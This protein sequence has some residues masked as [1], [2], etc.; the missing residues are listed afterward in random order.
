MCAGVCVSAHAH[1][2]LPQMCAAPGAVARDESLGT[3]AGAAPAP[4]WRRSVARYATPELLQKAVEKT[5]SRVLRGATPEQ[6]C[7]YSGRVAIVYA[8]LV[9][10]MGRMASATGTG[11]AAEKLQLDAT[12]AVLLRYMAEGVE[13]SRCAGAGCGGGCGMSVFR[14]Q[15]HVAV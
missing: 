1:P 14:V 8:Q 12:S 9:D 5:V 15:R 6:I 2:A 10:A 3:P 7:Y 11:K 4:G 13:R